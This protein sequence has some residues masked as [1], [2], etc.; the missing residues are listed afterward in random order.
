MEKKLKALSHLYVAVFMSGFAS[1]IVVPAII[2]VTMFAL[3]PGTDECSAAIYV[4]GIQQAVIGIGTALMMPLIGNLSDQYGRKSLLT[5][6]MALSI[7]PSAVLACSRT[8]NFFYA[9]YALRTLTAMICEG[10]INCLA[11]AYLADN[12]TD[13]QRASAFGILSGISSGAYVCA[14]LAA[15]F[16]SVGSTFQV[17]TIVS[18]LA[19]VYM[20]I[21]LEES[22]PDRDDGMT[23]PIL[24]E[25]EDA[26]QRDGNVVPRKMPAFKRIPSLGDIIC[27]LRSSPSFTQAA[28]VAFL[29]SFAEGGM[30]ASSMYYLKARF[31][32]NKNQF[33]DL[34]LIAGI[35]GTASQLFIMPLL[36]SPI[37]DGKLLSIG[38]FFSCINNIIYSLAWSPWVPYA[39]TALSVVMVYAS[40]SLRSIVSKQVGPAEQGKAQ[41]CISGVSSL[42][43]IIAPLI[44]SPVTALF[45]SEEAPFHFPGFSLLCVAVTLGIAFI[46]SLTIGNAPSNSSDKNSSGRMEV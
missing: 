14:T 21:F 30:V 33:A 23:Q 32:F 41:G 16:L 3:C 29:Y 24:K 12:I 46:L 1:S 26:I 31:H 27:L 13:S 38:L 11:L 2:D 34:L 40:P 10:S 35:I 22:I 39:S 15:R 5:L 43:N 7:I 8:T 4:S 36:V 18:M 45:L 9:Y 25:S 28:V 19:L 37:G 17:A 44:F 42:A 20:R 6:P